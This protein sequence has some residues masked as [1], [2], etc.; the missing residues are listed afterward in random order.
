MKTIT[1]AGLISAVILSSAMMTGCVTTT[2]A[3]T[4]DVAVAGY[5]K[6]PQKARAVNR[7][8]VGLAV[9][10]NKVYIQCAADKE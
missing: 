8:A 3:K 7:Q 10:P 6:A 9:H 5:C 2:I 4:M 1:K